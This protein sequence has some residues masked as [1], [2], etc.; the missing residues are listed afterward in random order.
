MLKTHSSSEM[1]EEGEKRRYRYFSVSARKKLCIMLSFT[2]VLTWETRET[3]LSGTIEEDY[4]ICDFSSKWRHAYIQGGL[5]FRQG[6][7]KFR[8]LFSGREI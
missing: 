7:E 4:V 2:P 3:K 8:L 1:T 5:R 6:K